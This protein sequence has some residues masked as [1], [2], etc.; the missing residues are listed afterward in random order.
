LELHLAEDH[1]VALL[2]RH[3]LERRHQGILEDGP[4]ERVQILDERPP[5][6]PEGEV[7]AGRLPPPGDVT[8]GSAPGWAEPVPLAPEDLPN[9]RQ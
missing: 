5:V 2:E 8:I 9:T 7:G 3:G 4:V 6:G 1:R